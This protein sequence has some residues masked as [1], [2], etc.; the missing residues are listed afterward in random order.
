VCR[1]F[2]AQAADPR[3]RLPIFDPQTPPATLV[4]GT[5]GVEMVESL[6]ELEQLFWVK[7]D[8]FPISRKVETSYSRVKGCCPECEN[9]GVAGGAMCARN[10]C[11]KADTG[12]AA[13]SEA[14]TVPVCE[15]NV[16]DIFSGPGE[17]TYAKE[18]RVQC[19][20]KGSV[21]GAASKGR[22]VDP[23]EDLEK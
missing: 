22:A 13:S 16:L 6:G 18:R 2:G 4:G 20:T 3:R 8:I 11:V 21:H 15:I 14:A 12:Q 9:N 5:K 1:G 19:D 7:I 23:V 17:F 10:R